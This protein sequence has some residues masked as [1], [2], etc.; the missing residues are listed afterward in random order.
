MSHLTSVCSVGKSSG[1]HL[2]VCKMGKIHMN[3][4]FFLWET[5]SRQQRNT[6]LWRHHNLDELCFHSSEIAVTTQTL[7]CNILVLQSVKNKSNNNKK[8]QKQK[9]KPTKWNSPPQTQKTPQNPS[10]QTQKSLKKITLL[11]NFIH[12]KESQIRNTNN[13]LWW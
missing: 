13:S 5:G 3:H 9:T 11:S 1:P 10:K 4:K 8:T 2:Q 7:I 6:I 12:A